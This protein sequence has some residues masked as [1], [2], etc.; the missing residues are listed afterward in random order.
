MTL[1]MTVGDQ[2][3]EFSGDA[4]FP[5]LRELAEAWLTALAMNDPATQQ[6][7]D[8]LVKRLR[9]ANDALKTSVD[10]STPTH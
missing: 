6:R 8:A 5:E 2:T 1:K 9:E 3:F 10:S 7:L 4:M